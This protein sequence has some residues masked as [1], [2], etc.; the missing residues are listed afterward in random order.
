MKGQSVIYTFTTNTQ[1]GNHI[2][3]LWIHSPIFSRNSENLVSF[4]MDHDGC[5][6]VLALCSVDVDSLL[7]QCISKENSFPL[8]SSSVVA[9]EG[10]PTFPSLPTQPVWEGKGKYAAQHCDICTLSFFFLFSCCCNRR[11]SLLALHVWSHLTAYLRLYS[12]AFSNVS[13]WLW[14]DQYI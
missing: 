8:N 13:A 9:C 6:D 11:F 12:L 14:C 7:G 10:W 4:N 1:G 5:P 2:F 3:K